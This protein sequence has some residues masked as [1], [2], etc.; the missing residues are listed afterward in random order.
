MTDASDAATDAPDAS[1]VIA[2]GILGPS[3]IAVSP[4]RVYIAGFDDGSIWSCP[5]SG[6]SGGSPELLVGGQSGPTSLMVTSTNAYWVNATNGS[7]ARCGLGGCGLMA[8][9][10]AP[11]GS[12]AVNLAVTASSNDVFWTTNGSQVKRTNKTSVV[13]TLFADHQNDAFAIA[14]SSDSTTLAWS[15]LAPGSV[16]VAK[17]TGGAADA[18]PAIASVSG[19][20]QPRS[21][22]IY[23]SNV[24]WADDEDGGAVLS[25]PVT[26]CVGAPTPIALGRASPGGLAV[27]ASGVYWFDAH[28]AAILHCPLEGCDGAPD[29]IATTDAP[30]RAIAIDAVYVYYATAQA[31]AGCVRRVVKP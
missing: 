3:S 21:V 22:A 13:T 23:G 29:V 20:P 10:L 19:Q 11:P 4:T 30:P 2:C 18:G 14:L 8:E 25:C 15:S 31:S 12:G 6:C 28:G 16:L 27:D 5:T 1:D 7:V 17:T 24:Y 26:G 9:A